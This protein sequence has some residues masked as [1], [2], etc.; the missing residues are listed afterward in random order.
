MNSWISEI[1]Y[2]KTAVVL[3]NT[4]AITFK[5]QWYWLRVSILRAML[6]LQSATGW[7]KQFQSGLGHCAQCTVRIGCEYIPLM[8]FSSTGA[9]QAIQSRNHLTFSLFFPFVC[10]STVNTTVNLTWEF[11]LHCTIMPITP[12]WRDS[13]FLAKLWRRVILSVHLRHLKEW[14]VQSAWAVTD[15]IRHF[16]RSPSSERAHDWSKCALDWCSSVCPSQSL[17]LLKAIK[18]CLCALALT[19]HKEINKGPD[20]VDAS[21]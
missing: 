14:W 6:L 21:H 20:R 17:I 7:N 10:A 12:K 5:T 13:P 19:S 4:T 8:P 1:I 9:S 16:I 3:G 15:T 11:L 18:A 2:R